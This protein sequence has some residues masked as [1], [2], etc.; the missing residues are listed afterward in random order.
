MVIGARVVGGYRRFLGIL[1]DG[2]GFTEQEEE[3]HAFLKDEALL[4]HYAHP[5]GLELLFFLL[6]T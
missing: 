6:L 4:P 2:L 3:G 5:S 1:R